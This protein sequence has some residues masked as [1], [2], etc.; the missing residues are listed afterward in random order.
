PEFRSE[1]VNARDEDVSNKV[2][3]RY[4]SKQKSENYLRKYT[5]S[6]EKNFFAFLD[7][8]S[9]ETLKMLGVTAHPNHLFSSLLFS[10]YF[11]DEN[12]NLVPCNE[13]ASEFVLFN[14]LCV[15]LSC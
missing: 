7:S 11:F 14:S 10:D 6:S 13:Y 1:F 5:E 9:K 12:D 3:H 15:A 8:M 2:W 4:L